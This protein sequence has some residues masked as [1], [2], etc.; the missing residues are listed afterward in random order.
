ME[1]MAQLNPNTG[2]GPLSKSKSKPFEP[3]VLLES[4]EGSIRSLCELAEKN[5]RRV[6]KLE[7]VCTKQEKEHIARIR[8]LE[9]MYQEAFTEFQT[10]EDRITYVSTKVVHLGDQLESSN[11]RRMRSMEAQNLM[12]YLTE[13]EAKSKPLLPVFTDS[14]KKMEAADLVFKLHTLVGELPDTDQY[15]KVKGH[16]SEKYADVEGTLVDEFIESHCALDTRRM[17]MYAKA[18]QPFPYGSSKVIENYIHHNLPTS[19]F[20]STDELFRHIEK[21]CKKTHDQIV[22]V[23][24]NP[25]VVMTKFVQAMIDRVIKKHVDN[26]L[27]SL[28]RVEAQKEKYLAKFHELYGKTMALQAKMAK[29]EM[30]MDPALLAKMTRVNLFSKYLTSY[31]DTETAHL[32]MKSGHALT[33]FSDMVGIAR[34]SGASRLTIPTG[35]NPEETYVSQEVCTSVLHEAKGAIRR[36]ETL[37]SG[38]ELSE[39]V[40]SIYFIVLAKLCNEH[41][42]TALDIGQTMD[43]KSAPTGLF[44][45][46]VGNVN[47]TSSSSGGGRCVLNT[48][49]IICGVD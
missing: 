17:K 39:L 25:D 33:E 43:P 7:H 32:T 3:K 44:C 45:L 9:N 20:S 37:L 30:T 14:S 38:R 34:K 12:K 21:T 41:F 48:W 11:N 28:S 6:D 18:L 47:P 29:Y 2:L 31:A 27:L 24:D 19:Q 15:R 23:F 22:E 46:V 26:E 4:F 10:L 13:F 42:H 16:I 40:K 1:K 8:D 35:R 49:T 36:A 5:Q